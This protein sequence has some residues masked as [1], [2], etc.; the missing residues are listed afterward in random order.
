MSRNS[1]RLSHEARNE[2]ALA[3]HRSLPRIEAIEASSATVSP[4]PP[5]PPFLPL[6]R[7]EPW[8]C[9]FGRKRVNRPTLRVT[10]LAR[11]DSALVGEASAHSLRPT[12]TDRRLESRVR[13][14]FKMLIFLHVYPWF[15]KDDR[16]RVTIPS[17]KKGCFSI[18]SLRI[19]RVEGKDEIEGW[20]D[21]R[22]V[23][24][25][26][27]WV[28]IRGKASLRSYLDEAR[29]RLCAGRYINLE[30]D[31]TRVTILSIAQLCV[32]KT[33]NGFS[34]RF[35]RE[36]WR[37]TVSKG[38]CGRGRGRYLFH[39][40]STKI[41]FPFELDRWSSWIIIRNWIIRIIKRPRAMAEENPSLL[42]TNSRFTARS[43]FLIAIH[44]R[45]PERRVSSFN[46]FLSLQKRTN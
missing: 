26:S 17:K 30:D 33:W 6:P 19:L 28:F 13:V 32:P 45:C 7:D 14:C 21:F 5:S 27:S 37:K 31:R 8:E 4:P 15:S 39:Y 3:L 1:I 38:K 40:R 43:I 18:L 35:D 10:L 24:L 2:C 36:R 20:I 42:P 41:A 12:V 29:C 44:F 9:P 23:P 25:S 16:A 22:F 11:N 34:G 46:L